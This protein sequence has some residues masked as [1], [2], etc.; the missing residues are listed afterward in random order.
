[1]KLIKNQYVQ[2]LLEIIFPASVG[3]LFMVV[4]TGIL[5]FI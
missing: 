5:E 3:A 4:L 2:R 1:M